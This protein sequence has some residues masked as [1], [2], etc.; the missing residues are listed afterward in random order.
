MSG[1]GALAE[2]SRV[3]AIAAELG[4]ERAVVTPLPGG[5]ANRTLRLQDGRHDYVLRL[6][7]DAGGALHASREYELAMLDL[8]ASAGLAPGIVLARPAEGFIVMRHVAGRMPAREDLLD[9]AFLR[10]VGA[11][12]ARLHALPPPRLPA[13]DFADRAAAYLG[14]LQARG[15]SEEVAAIAGRLAARRAVLGPPTRQAACHHD[16]HHRNFVDTG[17]S[18]V[19][20]DWEYAGPGDPAADLAACIGYHGLG[21]GEIDALLAGYG[22]DGKALRAR[23]DAL[24]W[25]FDC[26]WYGWNG[27][28]ALAG[29]EVDWRLQARLA[30]RLAA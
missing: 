28:A 11:W 5:L 10:R 22:E 17:R 26:L 21:P 12:I 30:A 23:I 25:I 4:L 16:L 2:D 3:G 7:G 29:L 6:A 13:I 8:A 20:L 18:L 15:G 14:D 9:P 24:G 1:A 19:V 27:V